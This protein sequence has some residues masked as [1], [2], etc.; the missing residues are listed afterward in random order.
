MNLSDIDRQIMAAMHGLDGFAA[1]YHASAEAEPVACNV[2]RDTL[3]IPNEYGIPTIQSGAVVQYLASDLTARKG[4]WFEFDGKRYIVES[5]VPT[6]DSS[7]RQAHCR[8]E[9]IRD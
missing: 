9:V 8:V 3:E 1:T 5:L 2:L 7:W 4:G 6:Q